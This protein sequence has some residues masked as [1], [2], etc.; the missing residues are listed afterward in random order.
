MPRV[1]LTEYQTHLLIALVNEEYQFV[2]DEV[3]DADRSTAILD[4]LK[5]TLVDALK[6]TP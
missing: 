2:D 6:E 4:D 3:E 5:A 1:N